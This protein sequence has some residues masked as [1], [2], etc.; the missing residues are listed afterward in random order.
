[1]V[2]LLAPSVVNQ[3]RSRDDRRWSYSVIL[4][5]NRFHIVCCQHLE[6]GALRGL[7]NCVGVF[8]HIERAV[9]TLLVPVFANR[10]G[11]CKDVRF[12]KCAAQGGATVSA[13][14]EAD[15]RVWFIQVGPP[16][17]KFLRP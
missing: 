2:F 11:N 12:V 13:G 10:L 16:L 4:L 15:W 6:S 7:R 9:G 3:N 1:M 5:N 14:G 8:P 17:E